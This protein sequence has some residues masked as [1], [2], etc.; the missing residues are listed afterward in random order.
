MA[1]AAARQSLW[2]LA[3]CAV[4]AVAAQSAQLDEDDDRLP[5][6][7]S[8]E[9]CA[10]DGKYQDAW[11][12]LCEDWQG[13]NCFT[14]QEWYEYSQAQ[15][16]ELL[17]KCPASC[18]VCTFEEWEEN[19]TSRAGTVCRQEL[20]R[21]GSCC[22]DNSTVHRVLRYDLRRP[23][24]TWHC[25]SETCYDPEQ[26]ERGQD[27]LWVPDTAHCQTPRLLYVHG[28][29]FWFGSPRSDGYATLVPKLARAGG[30]VALAL[31]YPL[32]PVAR[33]EQMVTHVLNALEYLATNGPPGCIDE[34]GKGP[35]I[36]IG[37]DSSGGGL[38][39][40]A[41]LELHSGRH[42]LHGGRVSVAGAFFY[43]PWLNM[44]CDTATYLNNAYS[45]TR[46][47]TG[48]QWLHGD[49]AYRDTPAK[50]VADSREN[51]LEYLGSEEKL[52][53]PVASP[54]HAGAKLLRGLPPLM[55]VVASNELIMGDT[56]VAAQNAAAVQ[57]DVVLD[58]Y[59]GLVTRV[60]H[61]FRGLRLQGAALARATRAAP[62]GAFPARRRDHGAFTV[63]TKASAE[64]MA[65]VGVPTTQFHMQK[66]KSGSSLLLDAVLDGFPCAH[67]V[68]DVNMDWP[69][70]T[71]V[72]MAF[73]AAGISI[74]VALL[75]AGGAADDARRDEEQVD[76]H[77]S[78]LDVAPQRAC[79][80]KLQEIQ[81]QAR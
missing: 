56:V 45:A 71:S 59:D 51:A 26:G 30:V 64:A 1:R 29:S 47:V 50:I 9:L 67:A 2:Q 31:D 38:A 63:R 76:D 42:S 6:H 27:I 12:N 3:T 69:M 73:S 80:W 57:V 39:Y 72:V 43:S 40:S 75:A 7:R 53:D 11:G 32:V 70:G 28:G 44:R 77:K 16:H 74:L 15:Q 35:P 34:P 68:E 66:G 79:G 13:H 33:Y 49:I 22:T 23:G 41:L 37:G 54:F 61:V 24:T 8:R 78:C 10:D 5:R 65:A 21:D 14:A 62:H 18:G 48:E 19:T 20:A 4:L 36:F 17:E 46:L 52:S 81:G 25:E 55:F 60:P 58:I